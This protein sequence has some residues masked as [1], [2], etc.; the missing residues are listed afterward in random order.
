LPLKVLPFSTSASTMHEPTNDTRTETM[1]AQC[2]PARPM[3]RPQ[4]PAMSAPAS[5]ASATVM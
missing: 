4:S 1:V 5:G 3:R 2:A